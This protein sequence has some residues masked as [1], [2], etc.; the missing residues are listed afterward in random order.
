MFYAIVAENGVGVVSA[1]DKVQHELIYL[2]G[3]RYPKR[4]NTFNE[5]N[6]F[7]LAHL[8][9]IAKGKKLPDDL[10]LNFVVKINMLDQLIVP[11]IILYE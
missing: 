8:A 7:A 3:F 6:E 9:T 1:W 10:P 2:K 4:F 11:F 5:A